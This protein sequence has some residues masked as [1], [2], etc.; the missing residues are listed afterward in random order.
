[1][2][3]QRITCF[4]VQIKVLTRG[5][6]ITNAVSQ[7]G[8]LEIV[9]VIF[10]ILYLGS[11]SVINRTLLERHKLLRETLLPDEPDPPHLPEHHHQPPHDA[12]RTPSLFPSC[13]PE[14]LI[15]HGN[16]RCLCFKMNF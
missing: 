16:L 8:D 5:I 4:R 9:L 12:R 6:E 1:M 2:I 15:P 3:I 7:F 10:D 11:S 13:L 14:V